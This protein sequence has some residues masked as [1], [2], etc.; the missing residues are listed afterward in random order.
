MRETT[1]IINGH[2]GELTI[3]GL[4]QA[5]LKSFASDLLP[6]GDQVNCARPI[7]LAPMKDTVRH[8]VSTEPSLRV[9]RI[10][11]NSVVE[12]PGRRSVLQLSGCLRNCPACYAVETFPLNSGVKMTVSEI[13]ELLLDP[14]EEPRDGVT[15]LGGEPLLQLNGLLALMNVLKRRE[16]HITLYTGYMLEEL[17]SYPD[18]DIRNILTL[19]DI[20]ID[21]PFVKE[22][23]DAAGEWRG[24]R[25][26]R[27][28]HNPSKY[29]PTNCT[30]E[31]KS[32]T[33]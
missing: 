3:E 17:H 9:F 1:W 20:L 14:E 30:R 18:E 33:R 27:I 26:Q 2:S 28:I 7:N 12:G 21:G 22:L 5:E 13:M 19:T 6:L 23:S 25:N 24:S 15:I 16:L 11:H 32:V 4:N 29:L 8:F 31:I 10:Y